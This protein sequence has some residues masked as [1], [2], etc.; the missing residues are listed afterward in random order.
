MRGPSAHFSLSA[1]AAA[2]ADVD[3][4]QRA[5]HGVEAGGEHDGVELVVLAAG[6]HAAFGVIASIGSALRSTSV[7]LS[8]L[9][10]SK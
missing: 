4:W 10:V 8:R 1:L 9:K 5:G 3:R 7:T 2:A 6:A